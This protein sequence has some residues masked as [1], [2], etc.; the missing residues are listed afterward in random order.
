M[1]LGLLLLDRID[2]NDLVLQVRVGE[3]SCIRQT[4]SVG[5]R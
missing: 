5:L 3:M 4:A 2:L 1:E